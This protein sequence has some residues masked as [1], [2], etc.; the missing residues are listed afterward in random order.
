[1]PGDVMTLGTMGCVYQ[2][3]EHWVKHN[4][5]APCQ[6][7][8]I[9]DRVLPAEKNSRRGHSLIIRSNAVQPNIDIH[10]HTALFPFHGSVICNGIYSNNIPRHRKGVL[11]RN[12][13]KYSQVNGIW[14]VIWKP[15]V[16]KLNL[17]TNVGT[18]VQPLHDKITD[19]RTCETFMDVL[20]GRTTSICYFI[21][22]I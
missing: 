21:Y 15:C 8:R 18:A 17:V 9:Q 16:P 4:R 10:V 14:N 12:V 13:I 19:K 1:M 3:L 5:L 6:K 22:N 20:A 11:V 7:S 2:C